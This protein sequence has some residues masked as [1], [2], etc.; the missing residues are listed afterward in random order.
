MNRL[1]T[2]TAD[3]PPLPSEHHQD[4]DVDV[5]KKQ[6]D[7]GSRFSLGTLRHG[8]FTFPPAAIFVGTALLLTLPIIFGSGF[9]GKGSLRSLALVKTEDTI[10]NSVEVI[11]EQGIIPADIADARGWGDAEVS[12]VR[13]SLGPVPHQMRLPSTYDV[14]V[15]PRPRRNSFSWSFLIWWTTSWWMMLLW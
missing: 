5:N 14:E 13:P 8:R 6:K 1:S 2:G 9:G 15:E 10:D 11:E 12:E 4:G 7:K 3:N